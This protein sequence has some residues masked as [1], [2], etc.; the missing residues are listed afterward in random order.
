MTQESS[1]SPLKHARDPLLRGNS[2]LSDIQETSRATTPT[3]RNPSATAHQHASAQKQPLKSGFSREASPAKRERNRS[4][5]ARQPTPGGSATQSGRRPSRSA[6][7]KE[8]KILLQKALQRANEAVRLD[9]DQDYDKA[10]VT[11]EDACLLLDAVMVSTKG[12]HDKQKLVAIRGTY[13]TRIKDLDKLTKAGQ[14]TE[15]VAAEEADSKHKHQVSITPSLDE[16]LDREIEAEREA[17]PP[18]FHAAHH[19][20]IRTHGRQ[21]SQQRRDQ[22]SGINQ[23]SHAREV[24]RSTD[25]RKQF[26]M[27]NTG[28]PVTTQVHLTRQMPR[29]SA[30][31]PPLA[32]KR[33]KLPE[34]LKSQIKNEDLDHYDGG[35]RPESGVMNPQHDLRARHAS[36]W[37]NTGDELSSLPAS[38]SS[39]NDLAMAGDDFQRA[40]RL[41]N[42]APDTEAEFDAALDAAIE[43]AYDDGYEPWDPL[44]YEA[45]MAQPKTNDPLTNQA[46]S[47]AQRQAKIQRL[48]QRRIQHDVSLPAELS[49][50]EAAIDSDEEDRL[51]AVEPEHEQASEAVTARSS[52]QR[53]PR[54]SDSS[55]SSSSH[56]AR[57]WGSSAGSSLNMTSTSLGT[58]DENMSLPSLHPK[59]T[60]TAAT[61]PLLPIPAEPVTPEEQLAAESDQ[62][63]RSRSPNL[64][65]RRRLSAQKARQLRI[66]TGVDSVSPERGGNVGSEQRPFNAASSNNHGAADGRKRSA[67]NI[68]LPSQPAKQVGMPRLDIGQLSSPYPSPS[69]H[70]FPADV[71]TPP[72]PSAAIFSP[73]YSNEQSPLQP[74]PEKPS[75]K[76]TAPVQLKPNSSSLSLSQQA[77]SA[78]RTPDEGDPSPGTPASF[79]FPKE[80]QSLLERA[81]SALDIPM[82]T[83]VEGT[84]TGFPAV[85]ASSV[86]IFDNEIHSATLTG[87]SVPDTSRLPKP[88]EACPE[89]V[90]LRPWWFM[91]NIY[92]TLSHPKGGYVTNK[93]FV[94]H[95][96]WKVKNVKL[97]GVEE[98]IANCDLLTAALLKLSSV[99]TLDADAVLEE[100]QSFESLLEMAQTNLQKKLGNEVGVASVSALFRDAPT[101]SSTPDSA[102]AH[103]DNKGN[104]T[105]TGSRSSSR[106]YLTSLKMLRSKS[107]STNLAGRPVARETYK[108]G[109][110]LGSIPMTS[111]IDSHRSRAMRREQSAASKS[112]SGINIDG[113]LANYA[114][115]ILRLCDAA[116]V[117]GKI[118]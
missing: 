87:A 59:S 85:G 99:D 100:M 43:S 90:L 34:P 52:E 57:T 49:D 86:K 67:E 47:Y 25:L 33:A 16:A 72:T 102:G 80:P 4:K 105:S 54:Q 92:Q 21:S 88:L 51:L 46:R 73:Q 65:E 93:L 37:L 61:A 8:K 96:V 48:S 116:Q 23:A 12:E 18:E 66:E 44:E 32:S 45:E 91:R 28:P 41:G 82:K 29:Q 26:K 79:G 14:A 24:S 111:S 56:S 20:S 101:E 50:E 60:A 89:S 98:K 107:S 7:D 5:D 17:R 36:S 68:A 115:A 97:K 70:A 64:R 94:P 77:A 38:P 117:L 3:P 118:V 39:P 113:P 103:A 13:L 109:F 71:L 76:H 30:I 42:L 10:T 31:P 63:S 110:T 19:A 11:Y 95:D 15:H 112:L 1:Y 84:F 55:V 81:E 40:H 53:V 69:M 75:T 104:T 22:E 114:G 2:N 106:G 6:E 108:E 27:Q 35:M 78:G 83:P 74:S 62:R 9:N 58:V